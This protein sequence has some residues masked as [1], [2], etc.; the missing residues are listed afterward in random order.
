MERLRELTAKAKAAALRRQELAA[1]IAQL[2]QAPPPQ[3]SG[4]SEARSGSG[5]RLE[6]P[7]R[8]FSVAGARQGGGWSADF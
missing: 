2:E 3:Q 1:Q 4:P 5:G 6:R 8:G 7:G